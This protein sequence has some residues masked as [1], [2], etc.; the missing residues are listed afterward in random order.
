MINVQLKVLDEGLFP[1][2]EKL[3]VSLRYHLAKDDIYIDDVSALTLK[4]KFVRDNDQDKVLLQLRETSSKEKIGEKV[5]H[6]MA[7]NW[8]TDVTH[9][10]H[11]LMAN[12]VSASV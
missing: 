5:I 7:S 8:L 2:R 11:A 1:N 3:L 9:E 10:A 6:Y 4:V 12:L